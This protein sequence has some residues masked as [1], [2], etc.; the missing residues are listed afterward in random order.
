MHKVSTVPLAL[1]SDIPE[2]WVHWSNHRRVKG[3]ALAHR[4]VDPCIFVHVVYPSNGECRTKLSKSLATD[5]SKL[6]WRTAADLR[7]KFGVTLRTSTVRGSGSPHSI[8]SNVQA[9]GNP[10]D[11][12]HH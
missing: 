8:M 1:V 2:A 9:T 10:L 11:R 3:T 6:E 12:H 5:A 7:I 4:Q